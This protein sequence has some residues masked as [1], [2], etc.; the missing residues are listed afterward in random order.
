MFHDVLFWKYVCTSDH[1]Y[2]E[3]GD[4]RHQKNILYPL[5]KTNVVCCYQH[6]K[7]VRSSNYIPVLSTLQEKT[8]RLKFLS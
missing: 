4:V 7:S 6:F 8:L 5:I 2:H 1:I 3:Q